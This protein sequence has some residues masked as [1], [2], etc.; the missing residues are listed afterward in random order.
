MRNKTKQLFYKYIT[1]PIARTLD[2]INIPK[3]IEIKKR[4]KA[5][6]ERNKMEY[7]EQTTKILLDTDIQEHLNKGE[8]P[9]PLMLPILIAKKI[10][11]AY[12]IF[13]EK[14]RKGYFDE[15]NCMIINDED[16]K[17]EN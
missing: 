3:R 15:L 17:I 7:I 6:A 16:L 4:Q 10:D 2:F 11:I 13:Y 12:E 14:K 1:T 5:I 9:H 8:V